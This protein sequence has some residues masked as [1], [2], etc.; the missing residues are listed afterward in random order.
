[1]KISPLP[2]VELWLGLRI[3]LIEDR[4]A[5]EEHTSLVNFY[6]YMRTSTEEWR[7]SERNKRGKFI[8][9]RQR[10]KQYVKN[11]Q[12]KGF[13]TTDRILWK[14]NEV[15]RTFVVLN[16]LSLVIRLSLYLLIQRGYMS[17]G[18]FISRFQRRRERKRKVGVNFLLIPFS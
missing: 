4:S 10:N 8:L 1:M 16:S 6:M 15:Y 2:S 5:A 12:H 7:P 3:K 14:S 17:Y 13:W 18:R 11:C 9:F